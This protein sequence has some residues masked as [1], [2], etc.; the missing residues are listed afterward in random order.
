MSRRFTPKTDVWSLGVTLWETFSFGKPPTYGIKVQYLL[1]YLNTENRRLG[2]E[3]LHGCP[4]AMYSEVMM[5]C[6][7]FEPEKRLDFE[8]ILNRVKKI[9]A[10]ENGSSSSC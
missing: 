5:K 9:E 3:V 7:E 4:E 1:H 10:N 8:E 6:W 2:R